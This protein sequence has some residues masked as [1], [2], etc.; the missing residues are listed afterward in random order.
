ML[1]CLRGV[2]VRGVDLIRSQRRVTTAGAAAAAVLGMGVGQAYGAPAFDRSGT[3]AAES[4]VA[5][6]LYGDGRK[7]LVA[8]DRCVLRRVNSSGGGPA[9]RLPG[10]I[11]DD[12]PMLAA[13]TDGDGREEILVPAL[14]QNGGDTVIVVADARRDGTFAVRPFLTPVSRI[15]ARMAW[16]DID[17]DG[18]PDLVMNEPGPG[19]DA[20]PV[21][22]ALGQ[23]GGGVGP[24]V[25]GAYATAG[26]VLGIHRGRVLLATTRATVARRADASGI[27]HVVA[28]TAARRVDRSVLARYGADRVPDIV[29]GSGRGT[30]TVRDGRPGGRFG[31]P[32]TV[33]RFLDLDTARPALTVGDVNRD[34]RADVVYGYTSITNVFEG[35]LAPTRSGVLVFTQRR[36]GRLSLPVRLRATRDDPAAIAIGR[37]NDDG[38]PDLAVAGGR[39]DRHGSVLLGQGR[40]SIA[41]V[42]ITGPAR[43]IGRRALDVPIRCAGRAG[44]CLAQFTSGGQDVNGFRAAALPDVGPG[45][46]GRVRLPIPT[47]ARTRSL[48]VTISDDRGERN[49][50]VRIRA[51]RPIDRR[52]ACSPASGIP[53]PIDA[54]R[55]GVRVL[56]VYSGI[57]GRVACRLGDGRWTAL[58]DDIGNNASGPLAA[59]GRLLAY[60]IASCDPREQPCSETLSIRSLVSGRTLQTMQG[61]DNLS[62]LT[63]SAA[64]GVAWIVPNSPGAGTPG[65]ARVVRWDRSG[66]QVLAAGPGIE[67]RSLRRIGTGRSIAWQQDGREHRA[68]LG[69]APTRDAGG[70]RLPVTAPPG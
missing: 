12:V 48:R 3:L 32:R 66:V 65:E 47:R 46:V 19:L 1:W 51:A 10:C 44:G 24:Q 33:A 35:N 26:H 61:G 50:R 41:R 39:F 11:V 64:G 60:S 55:S 63:M 20:G 43:R 9:T 30:I 49:E 38:D 8:L 31:P 45:Y 18:R 15:P 4:V 52:R 16:G 14:A 56:D 27:T 70:L 36:D 67:R 54:S 21:A 13:D 6:D 34:G 25:V 22:V 69:S 37:A 2:R 57:D 40:G 7:Q 68:S 23:P 59:N 42:V 29:T 58:G 5:A 62:D 17:G 28:R 53:V